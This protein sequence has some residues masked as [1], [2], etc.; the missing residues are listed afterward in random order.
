MIIYQLSKNVM[1]KILSFCLLV[2]CVFE[3]LLAQPLFTATNP[4][5]GGSSTIIV[6]PNSFS[7]YQWNMGNGVTGTNFLPPNTTY[8]NTGSFYTIQR[9]VTSNVPFKVIS[10]ISVLHTGSFQDCLFEDSHPDYYLQIKN[11]GGTVLY[12]SNPN[13]NT[14]APSTFPLSGIL[15]SSSLLINVWDYDPSSFCSNDNLGTVTLPANVSSGTYQTTNGSVIISVTTQNVTTA[16]YS[17][18]I[19]VQQPSIMIDKTCANNGHS[20]VLN[21]SLSGTTYEWSTGANTPSIEV[22]TEG[23][24]SVTVTTSEGC[25]ASASKSVSI[26]TEPT[27]ACTGTALTCTNYSSFIRWKNSTGVVVGNSTTFT[28]TTAGTYYAEYW[29]GGANCPIMS[30]GI[31]YPSCDIAPVAIDEVNATE[32][33]DSQLVFNIYPNPSNTGIYAIT[34]PR[35]INPMQVSIEVIDLTGKT[36]QP[37][38]KLNDNLDLS[39]YP[40]GMYFVQINY[41]GNVSTQKL[42]I[43]K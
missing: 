24:Y 17:R 21:L 12:Q 18:T 43:E 34:P 38:T 39:S 26:S 32:S 33:S 6:P 14:D 20:V 31:E 23:D 4:S 42:I 1:K 15:A 35:N 25:S 7:T 3:T 30:L 19:T 22:S 11:T 9:T 27:V 40:A 5:C 16:T 36:L 13:N 37:L 8:Y 41:N 28:P 2:L 10:A 29:G